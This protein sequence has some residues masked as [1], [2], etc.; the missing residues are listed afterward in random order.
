[1]M[2]D[3]RKARIVITNYHAFQR[4]KT[5]AGQ[6][7]AEVLRGRE[8]EEKFDERFRE[9]DGAD[10]PARDGAADGPARHHRHQRRGAS[11]LR[12]KPEGR[13]RR[14]GRRSSAPTRKRR[15]KP[16]PTP[17]TTTRP[18]A[19]GSTAS[20]RSRA[21]STSKPIYDL[22]ATPFFLRGSGYRE[23]ELFGWVVSDFSL[24]DAIE[25][26]IVKVPRVPTRDDV[27]QANEPDLPAHLQARSR[28][29]LAPWPHAQAARWPPAIC[30]SS[31]RRRC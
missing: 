4:T 31:S 10:D 26:G 9:T 15:P 21:C 18:P 28:A 1:M 24:M 27:I 19:S 23:G 5:H 11:L 12:A 2:G 3:L 25:S 14:A 20:E 30:R 29:P 8:S 22:S 7:D 13:R 6:G 16:R 17:S